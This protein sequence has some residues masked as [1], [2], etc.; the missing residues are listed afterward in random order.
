MELGIAAKGGRSCGASRQ[1]WGVLRVKKSEYESRC[2]CEPCG[3]RLPSLC[4]A[5]VMTHKEGEAEGSTG[6]TGGGVDGTARQQSLQ[7]QQR[8]LRLR[9]SVSV[10]LFSA[11]TRRALQC[12]VGH[13]MTASCRTSRRR[14]DCLRDLKQRF[15]VITARAVPLARASGEL[16]GLGCCSL[17][18]SCV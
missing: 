3:E 9:Y 11:R 2:E 12:S 17:A 13:D 6:R 10:L 8:S 5:L 1:R 4:S 15:G 7:H 18:T 14:G 16:A